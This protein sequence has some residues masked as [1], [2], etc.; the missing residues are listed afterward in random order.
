MT[1]SEFIT[2]RFQTFGIDLSEA[3]ILDICLNNGINADDA[4]S[5]DNITP[6][7]VALVRFIPNLLLRASSFSE[8]ELSMS[9]NIEGIKDFYKMKCKEYGLDD[10][11]TDKPKI[12]FL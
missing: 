9:W 8:N 1:A 2:Q 5:A 11:L 4:V 12:T 6:V 10:L 7:S 3:D